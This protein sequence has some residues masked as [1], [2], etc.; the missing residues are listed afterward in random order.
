MLEQKP[1]LQE[2]FDADQHNIPISID[3]LKQCGIY[4][5][6]QGIPP[7]FDSLISAIEQNF[8][9]GYFPFSR[10]TPAGL[11]VPAYDFI[12]RTYMLMSA[13]QQFDLAVAHLLRGQVTEI[14]GHIRRAIEGAGIA[15]LSKSKPELGEIFMKGDTK[16]LRNSTSTKKILPPD[17]PVTAPLLRSIDFASSL[18]H[19]NFISFANRLEQDISMEGSKWSFSAQLDFYVSDT[20]T[21]LNTSMWILRVMERVLRV[22]AASFD[23]PDCEWFRKL[24]RLKFSLDRFYAQNESVLNPAYKE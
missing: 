7:L 4:E 12:L 15:Y 13:H 9:T 2:M 18:I 17:D 21:I 1:F 23:L 6:Y 3:L 14:S 22:L 16:E 20:I 8:K 5:F 24:E 10:K 11:E 19:N